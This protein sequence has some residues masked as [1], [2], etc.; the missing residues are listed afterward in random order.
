MAWDSEQFICDLKTAEDFDE[1]IDILARYFKRMGFARV[2]YSYMP[3]VRRPDGR[4]L[5]PALIVRNFPKSWDTQWHRYSVHDPY[6]HACF[7]RTTA[8]E[9]VAVQKSQLTAIQRECVNYLADLGLS[10]GLTVPIHLPHGRFAFISAIGD[11]HEDDWD[12]LVEQC[13]YKILIRAHQFHRFAF[14]KYQPSVTVSFPLR[15][16]P[17]EAEC[18]NW[19]A[20]GRT[21]DETAHMLG[22]SIDTVRLHL[23]SACDKLGANNATHAVAKAVR[24][25]LLDTAPQ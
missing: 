2:T 13:R 21:H 5:P 10:K 11:N 25:R 9:W 16:T 20:R 19:I 14:Y 8:I 18:L 4:W 3:L 23:K 12:E 7:S 6:F 15:L 24:L 22:R 1:C 17:R